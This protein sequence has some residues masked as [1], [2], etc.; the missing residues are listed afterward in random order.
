MGVDEPPGVLQVWQIKGLR[1]AICGSVASKGLTDEF[2]ES[3]A[4]TGLSVRL[5]AEAK[6]K[7]PRKG[8]VKLPEDTA[9]TSG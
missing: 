2:L 3:V 4:N 7:L 5:R 1:E 6:L 8:T 9:R